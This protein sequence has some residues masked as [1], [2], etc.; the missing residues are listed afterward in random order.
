MTMMDYLKA[1]LLT[2]LFYSLAI[3][4]LIYSL[5]ADQLPQ[6]TSFS[7]LSNNINI[8]NV[9]TDIQDTLVK[10]THFSVVDLGALALFSGN[11]LLDLFTN[12]VFAL[13]QMITLLINGIIRLIGI[14]ANITVIV[15][16]FAT[17]LIVIMYIIGLLTLLTNIRSRG[18]VV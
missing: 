3:T 5:P 9:T 2:Q 18:S 12:F 7:D 11:I 4:L 14:D 1:I 13:P 10:E 15:Q 8:N 6:I 17:A 16:T